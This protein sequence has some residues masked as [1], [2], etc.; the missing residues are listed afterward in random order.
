MKRYFSL[1]FLSALALSALACISCGRH[2]GDATPFQSSGG[3]KPIVAVLPVIDNSK[4]DSLHWD[5]SQEMTE[6]IN[7]RIVDSSRL[8]LLREQKDKA[9]AEA[10]NNPNPKAINASAIRNL[11]DADYAIVTELV[12]QKV[13]PNAHPKV[14]A[15]PH[16]ANSSAT[17]HIAMRVR[18]LDVRSETPKVI[19]QEILCEDYE[20][21]RPYL[22]V[23]YT[24]NGWGEQSYERTPMGLAHSKIV[25]DLVAHTEGYIGAHRR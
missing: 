10:L 15:R 7:T 5:I 13:L 11:G 4:I 21:A 22:F 12:E 2:Y 17:L 25:R 1:L 18:V 9:L 19:L 24:K 8:Y 14:A 6:R 20:I 23:D 16:L 3:A